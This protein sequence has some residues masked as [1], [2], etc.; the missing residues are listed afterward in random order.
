MANIPPKISYFAKDY[1]KN[2]CV[3]ND[4]TECW[5]WQK[6]SDKSGYGLIKHRF[7]GSVWM[8]T[9]RAMWHACF[10]DIGEGQVVMHKCDNPKCC[11][12][13]HLMLGTQSDNM[14]DMVNKDRASSAKLKLEQVTEIREL[15]L[16]G[17]SRA[18]LANKYNVSVSTIALID[19]NKIWANRETC[20]TEN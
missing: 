15:L 6:S 7:F 20:N 14:R 18:E 9:H 1:I 2:R 8:Y 5:E 3:I 4:K 17:L 19:N 13:E 12:P 16:V 11:N 10:G